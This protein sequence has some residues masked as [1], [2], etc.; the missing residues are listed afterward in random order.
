MLYPQNNKAY[1]RYYFLPARNGNK[2]EIIEVI[3]SRLHAVDVPMLEEDLLLEPFYTRSV[4]MK[5]A[6]DYGESEIWVVFSTWDELQ[7]DHEK[8]EVGAVEIAALSNVTS[9]LLSSSGDL[10]V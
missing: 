1:V 5:E 8:Y 9:L 10:V 6:M 4:T 7:A 3:N 2:P